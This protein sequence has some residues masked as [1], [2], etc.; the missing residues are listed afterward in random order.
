VWINLLGG[1]TVFHMSIYH[2][3]RMFHPRRVA[4]VGAG[5]RPLSAGRAL[6]RNLLGAGFKGSI[7][8][9]NPRYTQVFGLACHRSI[10]DIGGEPV[11]LAVI[12][13][14]MPT[15]P[16]IIRQCVE[17]G[18]GGA[19]IISR[20]GET[21]GDP[22]EAQIRKAAAGSHLRVIGPNS[23][24]LSCGRCNLNATLAP[25]MPP[26]G[27]L[28]FVSQ[29]GALATAIFDAAGKE[30][31]GFSYFVS[32]GRMMD[33]NFGDAVDYLGNDGHV[34]SIVMYIEQLTCARRFM[35][36][37]RAVSTIKPIIA[38]KAGRTPP[39]GR[40]AMRH[41]GAATGEDGI[42]DAAFKR[43]GILRVKTFEELFDCAEL[44][45]KQPRPETSGI[46]IVSNAGGPAV[47]AVDA[48]ADYGVEPAPVSPET[49]ARL[50]AILPSSWSR[51]NPVDIHDDAS[52]QRYLQ[53][54]DV[55]LN[56]PPGS[57]GLLMMFSPNAINDPTET[58]RLLVSHLQSRS[59]PTITA[60]LGGPSVEAGRTL[61]NQAGIPTFN[62][63]ERAI[64]AFMDLY[65]FERNLEIHRQIPAKLPRRLN[66]DRR[67]AD[68][69]IDRQLAGNESWMSEPDAKQLLAAYGIAVNPAFSADRQDQAVKLAERIGYPVVLKIDSPMHAHQS[70]WDG[71]R[72]G[73]ADPDQVR[74]AF[75]HLMAHAEQLGIAPI[76]GITVQKML[77]PSTAELALEIRN[78][79]DFGPVL[80]FGW[81]GVVT[82]MAEDP[83]LALPPINRLLA[84]RMI[85][86]SQV[87]RLLK[88]Y[89]DW[90]PAN[91]VALEEVLIRL[92]QLATDYSQIQQVRINPLLV[93]GETLSAVSARV[94][95][96][97]STTA[98]PRH[99]VIAPYPNEYEQLLEMPEI[100]N[101]Q[102]RP[103]RPEDA[104]LL[105]ALFATLSQQ[106]V[107]FRFFAPL[108]QL[109]SN[110]L[111]RF[112]Q[113]DY[114]REIAMVAV[115][116]TAGNEEMM[117]VGRIIKGIDP[118]SAEF[119]I[120]V[121]DRWHGHGIG[122]ALLSLCLKIARTQG[123]RK[124]W[125]CVLAENT[126]MLNLGRKLHF[127]IRRGKEGGEYELQ[128][129][130]DEM[131]EI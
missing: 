7:H 130:L 8:P 37:A 34:S 31:V 2:L 20:A 102:I 53:V 55:L 24:G 65:H 64:R 63:P 125:G 118:T 74:Q 70:R 127:N 113:I 104:P 25:D 18:V 5:E 68:M 61:F 97:P 90:P 95:V 59:V 56:A 122:A 40:A 114:D 62:S 108:K 87:Y 129:D 21:N 80:A 82:D 79:S 60:W 58:A 32:L 101:I 83:V 128:M 44:V 69:L 112:T 131:G 35:S 72:L 30:R 67:A 75:D 89:R 71:V 15:V 100:G 3:D 6:M 23:L 26:P 109:P 27:R 111:A 106:T 91:M 66:F 13:T 1:A 94:C 86:E 33:V 73:L 92:S 45:S 77:G 12:I 50:D 119:S 105:K 28:A 17:A 85:E 36:A 11:D 115:R 76:R 96:A 16:G 4:V 48:L 126:Q 22:D 51:A 41:T 38:L 93:I 52:P 39:G 88:G 123:V 29:S 78:D 43:A 54:I 120:L 98:A 9:V 19:L 110:M 99:L 84:R 47:M 57:N 14:P 46:V 103:I 121:G 10:T 107:Y 42:Y 116:E 117:A 49:V 124:I 81:G